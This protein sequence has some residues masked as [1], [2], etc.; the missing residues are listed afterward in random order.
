MADNSNNN[1]KFFKFPRTEHLSGSTVVD[2]DV[3]IPASQFL[4]PLQLNP[5]LR[6]VVQEKVDGANVGVH[7]DYSVSEWEPLMQKRGGLIET[8]EKPQ[9]DVFRF[10]LISFVS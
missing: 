6:L 9:Y 3:S 10:V 7:F 1:T 5:N 8:S 2:D 4:K